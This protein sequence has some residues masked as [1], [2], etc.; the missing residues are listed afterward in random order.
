MLAPHGR[1]G[2]LWRR[3]LAALC[4]P[5]L[6]AHRTLSRLRRERRTAFREPLQFIVITVISVSC[7]YL[8]GLH[9]TVNCWCVQGP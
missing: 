7:L 1:P 5:M 8:K 6:P 2:G 3:T 9:M 4:S